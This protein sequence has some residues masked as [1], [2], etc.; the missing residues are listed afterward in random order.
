MPNQM[1][2]D[3][4]LALDDISFNLDAPPPDRGPIPGGLFTVLLKLGDIQRETFE[5]V[6]A[7]SQASRRLRLISSY[8]CNNPDSPT[9][10][11]ISG[12]NDHPGER[13]YLAVSYCWESS[14]SLEDNKLPQQFLMVTTEETR[15]PRCPRSVLFRA[16]RYAQSK[17]IPYI[18]IDQE[19]IEQDDPADKEYYIRCM[20]EIFSQ[21]RHTI[22]LLTTLFTSQDWLADVYLLSQVNPQ[23]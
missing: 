18:W 21:S 22:G 19:C 14:R 1:L 17:R 3:V 6:E 10:L 23:S 9:R 4:D 5:I 20:H 16:V 7:Q 15:K 8:T 2:R 12:P 11:Y 13:N